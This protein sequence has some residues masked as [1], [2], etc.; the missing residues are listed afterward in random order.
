MKVARAIRVIIRMNINI[1]EIKIIRVIRAVQVHLQPHPHAKGYHETQTQTHT[2]TH[3]EREREREN[4]SLILGL[5][6]RESENETA[7]ATLPRQESVQDTHYR[8]GLYQGLLGSGLFRTD[9][10][11][12]S[13]AS[14]AKRASSTLFASAAARATLH[15]TVTRMHS[16]EYFQS[17]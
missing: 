10:A 14:R 16:H 8:A 7:L 3:T 13:A 12:F 11:S 15:N 1:H 5:Q 4:A 17:D 9:L 6:E 2:L